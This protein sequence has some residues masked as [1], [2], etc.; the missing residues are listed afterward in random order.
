M[1]SM[2]FEGKAHKTERRLNGIFSTFD[3]SPWR[4]GSAVNADR[5]HN[6]RRDE[7]VGCQNQSFICCL[8]KLELLSR[9]PGGDVK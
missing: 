1:Y 5:K 8:I 3:L 6:G 2:Y 4:N 7:G 9:H